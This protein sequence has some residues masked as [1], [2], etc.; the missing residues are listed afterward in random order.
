[1]TGEAVS[2]THLD[3]YKRQEYDPAKHDIVSNASC[4]TNCLAPMVKVLDD[5]FGI[6]KGMMSTNHSYTCL[7]YTSVE[8]A[9]S[10]FESLSNIT[11]ASSI[12]MGRPLSRL[13]STAPV[14]YTHLDVYKRQVLQ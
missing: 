1:M 10:V 4:T 8:Y 7:L 2:Y 12:H 14:S 3:V 11:T 9:T 13:E 6:E 5:K